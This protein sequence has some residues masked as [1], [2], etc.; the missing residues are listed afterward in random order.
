MDEEEGQARETNGKEKFAN[1]VGF[2]G[3]CEHGVNRICRCPGHTNQIRPLFPQ[4]SKVTRFGCRNLLSIVTS[5]SNPADSLCAPSAAR[6]MALMATSEP[7]DRCSETKL[8]SASEGMCDS[9]GASC[10]LVGATSCL[11]TRPQ[12]NRAKSVFEDRHRLM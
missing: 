9:V 7:R 4:P 6:L 3:C 1:E 5:S 11:P 2:S 8:W 12:F 10:T